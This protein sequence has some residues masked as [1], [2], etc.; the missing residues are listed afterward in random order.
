MRLMSAAAL[1]VALAGCLG[2]PVNSEL[3]KAS[4]VC[5]GGARLNAVFDNDRQP[6]LVLTLADGRELHLPQVVSGS[7]ARY[8]NADESFVFWNKG[9]TAFVE[10]NGKRTYSGCESHS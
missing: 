10:E 3:I 2:R 1:A 9:N 8:A 6:N 5:E 7:G 4:F